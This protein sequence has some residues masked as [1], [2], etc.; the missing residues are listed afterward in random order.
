M[1]SKTALQH[2]THS[3]NVVHCS[4]ALDFYLTKRNYELFIKALV[5]CALCQM[6]LNRCGEPTKTETLFTFC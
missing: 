1:V 6:S 4:S 3:Q 2:R 5:E